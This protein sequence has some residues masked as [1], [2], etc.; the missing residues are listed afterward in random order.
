MSNLFQPSFFFK[1]RHIQTLYP[2]IFRKIPTHNFEIEKFE[3][4]D[5]DFIECYWY[6][7]IN[8]SLNRPIVILFHG[9]EGSFKSPYIQ[10]TMKELYANGFDSVVMHFRSCSGVMNKKANSYHSGKTDDAL[11]FL[12]SLKVNYTSSKI[13]AVGYSLGGNMLLKLLGELA[14]NSFITAA[15]S[16]SAP[17]ELDI[18][19]KKN[20]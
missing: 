9:L 8:K 6:K 16:V 19:A 4:S 10:G 13:F 2:S 20:E 17:M 15:V 7:K 18:C 1:N 3:L 5:G 11:E 12:E 14:Q